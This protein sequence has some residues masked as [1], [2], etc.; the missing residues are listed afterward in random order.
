MN[1]EYEDAGTSQ[2]LNQLAQRV[3]AEAGP[4]EEWAGPALPPLPDVTSDAM[5]AALL[6]LQRL[7]HVE[8]GEASP[9]GL[10][11]AHAMLE[12]CVL[13]ALAELAK[14]QQRQQAGEQQQEQQRQEPQQQ[15]PDV[16][17]AA[18]GMDGAGG[19]SGGTAQQAAAAATLAQYPLGFST[20]DGAAD[21]A[22]TILRMLYIKDLRALQVSNC[23]AGCRCWLPLLAAAAG[24]RCWLPLLAAGGVVCR[25]TGG[26]FFHAVW[27]AASTHPHNTPGPLTLCCPAALPPSCTTFLP[28]PCLQTLV[29]SAIVQVQEY[30]ANPRTDTTLGR[31][32]R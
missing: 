31:V 8:A 23:S 1:L 9:E 2:Q 7:L 22:A 11:R 17:P 19:G 6:Q 4:P 20:G 5:F 24:C 15:Q 30:T 13:P 27:S 14:Q 3:E 28:P 26:A 10:Q 29:D 25:R 21:L 16:P 12:S 18:A 32:G